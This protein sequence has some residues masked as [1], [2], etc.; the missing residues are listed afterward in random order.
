M[1]YLGSWTIISSGEGRYLG[2]QPVS[3][4]R[5]AGVSWQSN[6]AVSEAASRSVDR[7]V[8]QSVRVVEEGADRANYAGQAVSLFFFFFFFFWLI[9]VWP[10]QFIRWKLQTSIRLEGGGIHTMCGSISVRRSVSQAS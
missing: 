5:E 9:T 2:S 4:V 1:C 8:S 3:L 7:S 6:A 10:M